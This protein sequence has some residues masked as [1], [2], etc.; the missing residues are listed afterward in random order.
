MNI[1]FTFS[2]NGYKNVEV[3]C[4]TPNIEAIQAIIAH[5]V[6]LYA[7]ED[8][9]TAKE[10]RDLV[11]NAHLSAEIDDAS[12]PISSP[13]DVRRVSYE[14]I[15]SDLTLCGQATPG[16]DLYASIHAA[17]ILAVQQNIDPYLFVTLIKAAIMHIPLIA[18]V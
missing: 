5:A 18:I 11:A 10:L 13:A 17:S 4:G 2:N 7:S 9:G 16:E 14:I 8:F 12:A 1:T 15:G 3:S 6:D